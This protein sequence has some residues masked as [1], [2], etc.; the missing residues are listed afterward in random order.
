MTHKHVAIFLFQ[1]IEYF[2][3]DVKILIIFKLS[4][5]LIDENIDNTYVFSF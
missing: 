5:K 3:D 1:F 4:I 2:L